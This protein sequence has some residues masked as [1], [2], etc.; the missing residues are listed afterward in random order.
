MTEFL[1]KNVA[2]FRHALD[3]HNRRCPVDATAFLLY[4]DD[5]AQ[6]GMTSLWG[7]PIKS[8]DRVRPNHVRVQ[9]DGSAWGIEDEL[10][11]YMLSPEEQVAG[12]PLA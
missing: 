12:L 5:F 2:I 9:C 10:E 8:D 6:I 1:D 4:P 3:D 7:L 11:S